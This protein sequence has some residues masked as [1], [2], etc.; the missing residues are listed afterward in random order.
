MSSDSGFTNRLIDEK[1]PYL[2]QHAHN[3]VD[4]YP[5][6][7]EALKKAKDEDKPILV[8]I[9][10]ATCHWCHVMERESFEDPEL[11]EILNEHFVAI[12]VDREERPDVDQI[13]MAALHALG[14]GGGWP[15]NMFLNSDAVPFTGGTYFPPKARHG[16]PSFRTVLER[17]VMLWD[18]GRDNLEVTAAQL[19]EHLSS[20]EGQNAD[21][22]V[23]FSREAEEQQIL[24]SKKTYDRVDGGFQTQRNNKFPPSMNLMHLLRCHER[25]SDESIM[26]MIEYT[27][28]RMK[29]GGIYDQLGGGLSRYSTDYR[30]L[31][32]H[33]EKMLYDN[34]L[35]LELLVEAYQSTGKSHYRDWAEDAMSY[36]NRDMT[37]PE[38]AFF[39][40]ED[41]DSEGVEGK[42]YVWDREEI[43]EL[44][45][46]KMALI[47]KEYWG[48][49]EGGNFEGKT[50][51]W[52]KRPLKLVAEDCEVPLDEAKSLIAE[53]RQ[54]LL[55]HRSKRIRPLLDDK[56]LT[57][58]NALMI[59]A[60]AKAG[61]AFGDEDVIERAVKAASFIL[62]TLKDDSGRL[63]RRYRDGEARYKA[64]L[65]DHGQLAVACLDLFEATD[66][67]KWALEARDLMDQV[68]ALFRNEEGAY[69][70]TGSDG[71]ALL[72]RSSEGYDGVEPSGN[73]AC[74]WAFIRLYGVFGRDS[75]RDDCERILRSY[76]HVL[77]RAGVGFAYMMRSL[78]N[79]LSGVGQIVLVGSGD[80]EE[81][82]SI[83]GF[84]RESFLPQYHKIIVDESKL[85]EWQKEMPVLEN[86][87]AIEGK[88][89]VYICHNQ[90][91]ELP[92]HGLKATKERFS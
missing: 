51:L 84:L 3:P 74:S 14:E 88:A 1:S 8:S 39:S 69:Y 27:I 89:T 49:T 30:W 11:A 72:T 61:R 29:N 36:L 12:K 13:Y 63:L 26:D 92:L 22:E 17:I 85:P 52:V 55:E 57:S 50:I 54:I 64:Y 75:D 20:E 2:L 44:L 80:D 28:E 43:D 24:L 83:R 42:F 73:S 86:R 40:A 77:R 41:A 34:A 76:Y 79:I 62:T 16:R 21:S 59:S 78:D 46:V 5:W 56:V 9:G 6:G 31:V 81:F 23:V 38:G 47:A 45:P 68:N 19:K 67:L 48:V 65:V 71:E 35:W 10:Y 18:K 91:C 70:D 15:L 82:Q 32:P 7:E 66:D 37:N 25:E 4:W 60:Y 90:T 87:D 58:W 53:A 33:F